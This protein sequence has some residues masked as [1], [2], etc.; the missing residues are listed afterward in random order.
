VF[1]LVYGINMQK[2]PRSAHEPASQ[3][4]SVV[5]AF[6]EWTGDG[7]ESTAIGKAT[8]RA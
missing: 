3:F 7:G 6:P 1:V 4:R 5:G 8:G 2:F